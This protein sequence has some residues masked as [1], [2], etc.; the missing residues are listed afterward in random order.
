MSFS[1]GSP[2]TGAAIT[3]LT[4]PTFTLAAGQAPN[5]VSK[6]YNVT[7]LG[8]TQTGVLAHGLS[9]PFTCTMFV[10]TNIKVLGMPNS[11]GV[12][13][14]FPRNQFDLLIRKGMIPLTGQPSQVAWVR[15]MASIPAGCDIADKNSI[16][17]MMSLF[18]GLT[19]ASAQG[20]TDVLFNATL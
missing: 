17:S 1:P 15:M 12:I 20:I 4:S 8:G 19:W 13:R 14:S 7:N 3:G 2:V 9:T 6:Q 11:S 5:A 18:S 10:P 16:L